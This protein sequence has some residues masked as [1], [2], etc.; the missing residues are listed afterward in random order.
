MREDMNAVK[1][2]EVG[3]RDGLQNQSVTLPTQDKVELLEALL[4]AGVSHF[5]LTSFVRPDAVPQLADADELARRA[6]QHARAEFMALVPNMK[7]YERARA[8]GIKSFA[9]VLSV[10]ETLNQKNINMSLE[11]ATEVCESVTRR[12]KENG[13]QMRVYLAAAVACPYDGRTPPDNVHILAH[14]MI[15]AGADSIAVA[16]TI[17][18]GHPN[19]LAPIFEPLLRDLGSQRIAAHFHDTR[20]LGS[21]LAWRAYELGVRQFDGSIGGLGGCP[22]APGASGNVST[23]DLVFLFEQAGISTGVNLDRLT[24]ALDVVE[25]CL[26]KRHQGKIVP[27]LTSRRKREELPTCL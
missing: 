12:A 3:L 18:A 7:G 19:D 22:F 24:G 14:R 21:A 8:A 17:G 2:T 26:G 4:S 5:E 25:R 27:W 13:E 9:L 10:S 1:L 6:T 11:R 23:E 20:G 15:D 16:D